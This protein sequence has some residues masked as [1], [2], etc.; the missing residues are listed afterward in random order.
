MSV[1]ITVFLPGVYIF[2]VADLVRVV[3]RYHV[4]DH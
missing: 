4:P 3:L 1:Y 2:A